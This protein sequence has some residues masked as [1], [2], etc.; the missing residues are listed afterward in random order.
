MPT[1]GNGQCN[2]FR[3]TSKEPTKHPRDADTALTP[4]Y[5]GNNLVRIGSPLMLPP[6]SC[7]P[8]SWRRSQ[9]QH[10]EQWGEGKLAQNPHPWSG[11]GRSYTAQEAEG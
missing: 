3:G 7:T 9:R 8:G 6:S 1:P 4:A 5:K 11:K 2:I 10:S